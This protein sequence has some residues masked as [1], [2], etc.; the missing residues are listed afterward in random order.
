MEFAYE[1]MKQ[2]QEHER[3]S[4]R[5]MPT[6]EQHARFIRTL[7]WRLWYVISANDQWVGHIMCT[8]RN[9]IGIR[10]DV[11]SQGQGIGPEA[12]KWLTGKHAPLPPMPGVRIGSWV[13]NISSGNPRSISMFTKL[14]FAEIQRTYELRP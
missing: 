6:F 10:L 9:E 7:P 4:H 5:S 8:Y 1:L 13:A 11:G 3:V 2:V 12:V 14:G